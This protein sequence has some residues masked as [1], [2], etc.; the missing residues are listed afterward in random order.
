M[1]ALA[2]V[3]QVLQI[4]AGLSQALFGTDTELLLVK[5]IQCIGDIGTQRFKQADLLGIKGFGL[6]GVECERS[7]D[8]SMKA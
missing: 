8:G 7:D 2:I 5:G 4:V 6:C 1:G 3:Y